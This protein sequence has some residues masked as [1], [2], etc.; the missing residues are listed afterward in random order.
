M[1]KLAILILF[2][3]VTNS[4]LLAQDND[5]LVQLSGLVVAGDSLFG[6]QGVSVLNRSERKGVVTDKFGFFSFPVKEN[7]T[8]IFS[9]I[10]F[11]KG[12]LIIPENCADNKY[13]QIIEMTVDT[14]Q[15]ITID[16]VPYPTLQLF[17]E[18]FVK[19]RLEDEDLHQNMAKNLDQKKLRKMFEEM[20]MT[21]SMN[22]RHYSTEQIKRYE[23]PN[24]FATSEILNPFAW[25]KLIR[26]IKNGDFKRKE[27]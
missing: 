22:Y 3:F 8:I 19:L 18:A 24:F 26:A 9:F 15:L 6:V 25:I 4:F 14:T 11:E 13:T 12:T 7:D 23:Q 17:K 2:T 10:G 1:R 16:V 27:D 20:D 21:A 5:E